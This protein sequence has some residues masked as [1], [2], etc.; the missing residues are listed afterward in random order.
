M[1]PSDKEITMPK[2]ITLAYLEETPFKA[3]RPKR[4]ISSKEVNRK[5]RVGKVNIKNRVN[6]IKKEKV[7][8][9]TVPLVPEDSALMT[10]EKFYP[11]PPVILE[12]T[13]TSMQTKQKFEKLLE[14][15]D[16]IISKHSLDIGRTPLETMTID[17]KPGSKPATSKPYN[18]TLKNQE[19]LKQELKAL[20]ESGVIERSM[21]P[22]AAPIIVVN[23]K[24][25]PGAPMK[26]QKCLVID[27][28]KLNQQLVMAESAQNKSKGLLA[29]ILTPKIEHIWYKLRK[30]KYL[31]TIDLRSGYH[32][33][34]I[35][36]EICHKSVF[37]CEYGKFEFKRASFGISTCPDY[38]KSLMNK[39]FF[40]C[41]NFCIVYMDDLLVF[42]ESKEE[43]LKHLEIIF[44]KFRNADL[45]LKLSKCQF[46]K[47][48]IEYLGH[49][50]SQEGIKVM[51]DKI[52]TVL[53]I[54]PPSNVKEAK[55]VLGI[56]GYVASFI[57]M[58]SEVVRHINRLTRKNVPFVWDQK[59]QNSLDLA[60]EILTSPPILV[61]PDP[62]EKYHLFTD[63]SN[64]T[65]SAALMQDRVIQTLKGKESKFLPIAF[66]SGTFQGSEVNWAAFQKEAAAI[67]RGIKW[68]SFYLYEADVV[69]HS[70]H[71]PLAKFIDG[72]TK[73][74]KVNNWLWNAMRFVKI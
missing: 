68:L 6:E 13:E 52:N 7:K 29:L 25:K 66:H 26:E 8:T 41:D 9:A 58:Y 62:N 2:G 48:E 65:W 60:K 21:S 22:Y 42:S 74:N 28:R 72:M 24:C 64:F 20:L 14:K 19:F 15:Y 39:L 53:R 44:E 31:S 27:Y 4:T 40:D 18:T 54:K 49:L 10:N 17:V 1:N 36:E 33:I 32:H 23:R 71:K 61:Y 51:P 73:N 47:K 5:I 59:C 38:L 45:K 69:V 70:D 55:S 11:K 57:P 43:H 34:P 37:V 3:K 30:A 16:D 63:A 67:H 35:A 50:V 46:W 12:N 56:M